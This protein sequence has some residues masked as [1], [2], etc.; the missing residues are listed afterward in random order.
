[1][2]LRPYHN[3]TDEKPVYELWQESIGSAWM[4]PQQAFHDII[5]NDNCMPDDHQVLESNGQIIGFIATQIGK[6][7]PNGK[8]QGSLTL[9]MVAPQYQQQGHGRLLMETAVANLKDKGVTR[10]QL[11]AGANRYF[12]PGVPTNLPG[13][14]KFFQACNWQYHEASFDLIRT[15]EDY[16]HPEDLKGEIILT[17]ATS[18]DVT[19]LLKFE[20]HHFPNWYQFFELAAKAKRFQEILLVRD[21]HNSIIG[22]ALSSSQSSAKTVLWQ[23]LIDQGCGTIGCL[24][25]A[26][27]ARERGV[28]LSIADQATELL[29]N[30]GF[31]LSYLGWTWLVDWYG[32][33][34]YKVWREYKMSWKDL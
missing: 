8:L 25:V 29:K 6:P 16:S 5:I 17:E 24:G 11:G 32:K 2:K 9:L 19:E 21:S 20:K 22:T 31:N 7:E 28:G 10:V 14:I 34:G 1:M 3:H 12:W 15:L 27:P 33:L 26:E 13:A 4:L 23:E 18:S 30:R